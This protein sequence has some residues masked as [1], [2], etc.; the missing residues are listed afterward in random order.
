ME[1]NPDVDYGIIFSTT[2]GGGYQTAE[3]NM[4]Y[5]CIGD[6]VTLVTPYQTRMNG[7]NSAKS[8]YFSQWQNHP[9]FETMATISSIGTFYPG[10][11]PAP[12]AP[13]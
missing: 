9:N 4:D 11:F 13:R 5:T 8:D 2:N 3:L 12:R 7:A 1:E 6:T 10:Q